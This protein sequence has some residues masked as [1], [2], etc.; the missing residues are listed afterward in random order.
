M[1]A[2]ES[3]RREVGTV[4]EYGKTSEH[5][6]VMFRK[7][8]DEHTSF[9]QKSRLEL[10]KYFPKHSKT[11][12]LLIISNEQFLYRINYFSI[13]YNFQYERLFDL[14]AVQGRSKHHSET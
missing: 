2:A 10:L 13:F 4:S 5:L 11:S 3:P 7:R 6:Q 8:N 14:D 9:T 1:P 12:S